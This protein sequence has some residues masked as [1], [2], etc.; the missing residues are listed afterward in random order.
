[1][2]HRAD[3]RECMPALL[4]H[5][6]V[7]VGWYTTIDLDGRV[8]DSHVSRVCC[9]FPDDGP[10]AYVQTNRFAWDDGRTYQTEFGGVLEGDR[11]FWDTERFRGYGWTT[12]DNVVLLTLDRK[13]QPGDTFTEIIVLAPDGQSRGRTWHWFRNGRLFQRTLCDEHR[14]DDG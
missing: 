13:D 7:W 12:H 2:S 3:I 9:E 8:V 4:M 11:I 14:V 10:Y 6:G 1:M 5:E